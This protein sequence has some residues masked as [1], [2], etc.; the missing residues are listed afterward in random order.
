MNAIFTAEEMRAYE[1]YLMETLGIPSLLLM[2]RAAG[3]V[4]EAVR[5]YC[6][7]EQSG[8]V[9]FA[10]CGNNGADGLAAARMLKE[11]AG[12]DL[13]IVVVGNRSHASDSWKVQAGILEKM[14][15]P[16]STDVTEALGRRTDVIVDAIFGIGLNREIREEAH[17]AVEQINA[18]RNSHPE[19]RVI[20]V[21]VPSGLHTD[22][23]IP[24]PQAV[25][26]DVTV[27]FGAYK[28]GLFINEGRRYSGKVSLKPIGI[29]DSSAPARQIRMEWPGISGFYPKRDPLGHK[30]TFGKVLCIAG[31]ADMAGAS[32]LNARSVLRAGAGMVKVIGV[33]K[34]RDLLLQTVP[35]AMFSAIDTMDAVGEDMLNAATHWAD[36]VLLG[37]GLGKERADMFLKSSALRNCEKPLVI[38]ADGLNALADNM[39]FLKKRKDKGRITYLTPHPGEYARLFPNEEDRKLQDP[40]RTAQLAKEYGVILLAKS[41]TTLVTNG[42]KVYYN[43]LGSDALAT[44]GSGDVLAGLLAAVSCVIPDPLKA[45]V[46]ADA[47]HAMAGQ[48]AA[49][50]QGSAGVTASDLILYL[51]GADGKLKF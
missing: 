5:Q 16:F 32:I 42:D 29:P 39:E 7:E 17:K 27:T 33:S 43:T 8:V 28:R 51:A 15:I 34:N 11:N 25:Y 26:A 41:A 20:S 46:Y 3:Y 35:E 13:R 49:A 4:C 36:T 18:Y 47:L 6:T 2:E 9:V 50:K 30:G 38:D 48:M 21:D 37:S 14:G 40:D 44:A 31:C 22:K 10:G 24:M 45:A 23:G 1:G 12:I 19:C